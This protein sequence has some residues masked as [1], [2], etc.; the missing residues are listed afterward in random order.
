MKD[1]LPRAAIDRWL[2]ATTGWERDV[3]ALI[4]A[5]YPSETSDYFLAWSDEPTASGPTRVIWLLPPP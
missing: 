1:L 3:L 2:G 4:R 5:R